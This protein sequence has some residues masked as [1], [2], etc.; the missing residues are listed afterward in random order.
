MISNRVTSPCLNKE[1]ACHFAFAKE[2]HFSL[3]RK[4]SAPPPRKDPLRIS[5]TFTRELTT[6]GMPTCHPPHRGIGP[7]PRDGQGSI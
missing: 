2:I 4:Y 6:G 5:V 3:E 7:L 1:I